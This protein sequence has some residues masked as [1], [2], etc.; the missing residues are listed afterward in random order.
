MAN[1]SNSQADDDSSF[2]FAVRELR[3]AKAAPSLALDP[4]PKKVLYKEL[5]SDPYNSSGSFD[6]KQNWTRI[7]KR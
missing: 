2:S 3:Q 4:G 7:R 5:G 6:R 1:D